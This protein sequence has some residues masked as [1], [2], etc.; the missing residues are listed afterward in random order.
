MGTCYLGVAR[1]T[2]VSDAVSQGRW[3]VRGQR[4]QYFHDLRARIQREAV[5]EERHGCD[6]VLWKHSD[7]TY[8][9]FFSSEKT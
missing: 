2:L 7:D 5:P 3:N 9:P 8:K 1:N 4:S 6:V